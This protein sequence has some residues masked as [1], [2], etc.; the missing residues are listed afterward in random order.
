M[1]L[2]VLE[3]MVQNGDLSLEAAQYLVECRAECEWLDFKQQLSLEDDKGIADFTRD[4][5]AMKN[6]GGGYLVIGV[7]DKTWNILGLAADLPYDGK[8]LR[9][10]VR[11][12]SGLDLDLDIVH[13]LVRVDNER[14]MVAII[15]VRSSRRR[16]KRRT[17][18]LVKSDFCVREKYGLRRGE[19]YARRGDSTIRVDSSEMLSSLLDDLEDRADSQGAEA[20]QSSG[21]FAIDAGLFRLQSPDYQLFVGRSTLRRSV[22]DAVMKDPRIWIINIHGPGGVGKSAIATWTAYHFYENAA[23]ESI[24]QLTA[25]ETTLTDGGIR[26]NHGRTLH[27]LDDL[28][29]RICSVFEEEP[30]EAL[31]AKKQVVTEILSAWSCLLVLDNMETVTDGRIMDF[32]QTLPPETKAKV[33]LTSRHRTGGW[34][35]PITVSEL[36]LAETKEFIGQ[37]SIELSISV[38]QDDQAVA[39]F[40]R[41]SGGLPLALQWSLGQYRKSRS[42]SGALSAVGSRS[43]PVLEF[44]F[45]NIW[46]LL[47]PDGKTVLAVLSIFDD[48]PAISLITMSLEWSFERVESAVSEL[49]EVT[50]VSRTS[51]P[52]GGGEVVLALPITLSFSRYQLKD[53]GDLEVRARRAVQ[54]YTQQMELRVWEAERFANIFTRYQI[55]SDNE[56]RA[57]ILCR[58]GESE[59]FSGDLE[60]AGDSFG[61]ARALSPNSSYVFAMSANFELAAKRIGQAQKFVQVALKYV[62][63]STGSMVWGVQAR[64]YDAERNRNG[65]I[66]ALRKALQYSPGDNVLRHQ[67]GVALSRSRESAEAVVE[68]T[69]IVDS[70]LAAELPSETLL[71]ALKTRIINLRRLGR[72]DEANEDLALAHQILAKFPHLQGQADHI[73]ELDLKGD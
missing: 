2:S 43:S 69:K 34:E 42:L 30:P 35:F 58:R 32:V 15:L 39:K 61:Q 46:N 23:F 31:D 49:A 11:K 25:K 12:G 64:V 71:M 37:K 66:H 13:H 57:A 67:L 18:S 73:N 51:P 10:K 29:D 53:M 7:E 8:L 9:D 36:D 62:T 54:R 1:N 44:S 4:V 22:V 68:F 21:P 20:A 63:K 27:S 5:L 50:L 33:I 55:T 60:K 41:A 65:Q 70:E 52:G 40:W 72:D 48:P 24:I 17:P 59:T 26:R 16:R 28:L 45:R 47:S 6:T 38:P 56:K 19:I 3:R 14:R